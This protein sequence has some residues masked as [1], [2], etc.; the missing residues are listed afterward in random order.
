MKFLFIGLLAFQ[1]SGTSY[2]TKNVFPF[3]NEYQLNEIDLLKIENIK[4]KSQIIQ[5]NQKLVEAQLAPSAQSLN[6]EINKFI[7]DMRLK[8]KASKEDVFNWDTLKFD[9]KKDDKNEIKK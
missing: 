2:T 4:L 1:L 3:N 8:M 9:P 5:L 6:N 7:E